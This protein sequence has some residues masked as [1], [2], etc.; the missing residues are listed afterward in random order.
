MTEAVYPYSVELSRISSFPLFWFF[1]GTLYCPFSQRCYL[2]VQFEGGWSLEPIDTLI[3]G[4]YYSPL[5]LFSRRDFVLYFWGPLYHTSFFLIQYLQNLVDWLQIFVHLVA[6]LLNLYGVIFERMIHSSFHSIFNVDCSFILEGGWT[7]LIIQCLSIGSV[8]TSSL[9][10]FVILLLTGSLRF[11]S[12]IYSFCC[13]IFVIVGNSVNSLR[14]S[15]LCSMDTAVWEAFRTND[16]LC[17]R[18]Y[19]VIALAFW[20]GF[21]IYRCSF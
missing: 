18:F 2:I 17:T 12:S 7:L 3:F 4:D 14:F 1:W 8:Y 5:L 6:V 15:S 11:G 13:V 10:L 9:F 20:K 21:F 19:M 16:S